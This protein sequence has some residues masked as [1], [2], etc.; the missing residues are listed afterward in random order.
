MGRPHKLNRERT[1]QMTVGF[2]E[3]TR[4]RLIF[5]AGEKNVS[6]AELVRRYVAAGLSAADSSNAGHC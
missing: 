6:V 3:Q 2:S 4:R 5:E 1:Q